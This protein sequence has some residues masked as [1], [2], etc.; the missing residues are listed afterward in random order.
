MNYPTEHCLRVTLLTQVADN[1]NAREILFD[2]LSFFFYNRCL[3][4]R[5]W[6]ARGTAVRKKK[7][8]VRPSKYS[9]DSDRTPPILD[10][11]QE[12]YVQ[13]ANCLLNVQDA[14][15]FNKIS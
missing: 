4:L 1:D 6:L 10:P 9:R 14:G 5:S 3:F 15:T 12:V 13:F 8:E 7:E 2:W 11:F